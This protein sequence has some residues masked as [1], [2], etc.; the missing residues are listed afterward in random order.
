LLNR[1]GTH[2]LLPGACGV[3]K[4]LLGEKIQPH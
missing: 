1:L 3:F 2:N 4:S